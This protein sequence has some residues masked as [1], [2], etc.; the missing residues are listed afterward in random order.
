MPTRPAIVTV[1]TIGNSAGPFNIS[2]DV[3]GV[4]AMGVT[5]AQLQ[6][7]YTVNTDSNSTLITVTSTGT[8]TNSVSIILPTPTPTVVPPTPTP[9]II[10]PTPTPTPLPVY[11][12][13]AYSSFSNVCGQ[14][15]KYWTRLTGPATA[16]VQITLTGRHSVV[17]IQGP[18]ACFYGS[19]N[20][21]TLPSTNPATGL[22][23]LS[24]S[25]TILAAN[26]PN[27]I[28]NSNTVNITIP[29]T[30]YK[31]IIIVYRT[32]NLTTNFS[33]GE[34]KAQITAVNGT[35]I[36]NGNFIITTY[37]CSDSGNCT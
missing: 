2:D 3:L 29:N 31:D 36:V 34:L 4:I 13:T 24:V 27:T 6:A 26:V 35:P 18:S 9:T 20:N 33:G 17:G 11:F 30:G 7:G 23:L 12:D 10:L 19:L 37:A 16:V 15:G 5:A 32:T 28:T 14:G 8:C 25:S 22:E 1:S 21:T